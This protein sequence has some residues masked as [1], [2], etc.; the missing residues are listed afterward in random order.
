M[1]THDTR[2]PS[3]DEVLES[4]RS[5]E[6]S[7][8][9]I[10]ASA[11]R[12][13]ARLGIAGSAPG[14]PI[15]IES[16]AGF[17]ALIPAFLDG[18]LP[19]ETALLL[20]DHTRECIPCRRALI[21]ARTPK[22]VPAA[23]AAAR[24]PYVRWAAAAA[25]AAVV[26]LGGYT[27]WQVLPMLSGDPKL[28]VVRVDGTLYQVTAGT[29]V[30]LRP[31]M[32]VPAKSGVRTAKDSG[33]LL[34]IDDGSRIEMRER[35]DLAVA[36]RRDGSTVRLG[37]GAI[38]VEASPQGAGHLDVRTDDCQVAVK[39]T[40]FSVNTGTKGSRVSVVEGAVEV[41]ADGRESLLKPGDQMTTSDSV[42]PVA[43][44]DEIA[45]SKDAPRYAQLLRELASLRKDLDARVQAPGMRFSSDLLDRMP[46][47]TILYAAIPNLT[48]ALVT[49][50]SVFEE[51]VAQ[52]GALQ[53]W[54]TEHMGSPERQKEMDQAFDKIKE[55]GSQL[56]DEIVLALTQSSDG[57]I[58]GPIL[59][60]DVKDRSAFRQ[61]VAKEMKGVPTDATM[62]FEGRAVRI[63][64]AGPHDA[65]VSAR[66]AAPK[67]APW[68]A[69]A[70]REKLAAAYADGTSWLFGVDLAAI[71]AQA[72]DKALAHGDAHAALWNQMGVL[73]A[74]YLIFE[75][76]DSD[77]GASLRAEISFDQPRRGIVGWLSSPAPLGAAD[78]VSPDAAFAAAAVTKRPEL[79]LAEALSWLTPD[80]A[81]KAASEDLGA[82]QAMAGTMGGDVAIALDGPVLPVPS[83]KLAVEVYDPVA[84]QAAFQSLVADLNRR[85]AESG[86]AGQFVVASES[87]GNRT[88]WTVRFTGPGDGDHAMRYTFSNGYLVAA[89]SRALLDQ[90]IEQRGNGYTL[91]RSKDFASLLPAD[92]QVNVSAF[93]WE[94]LGPTVGPLA[95]QVTGIVDSDQMKSIEAM[96]AESHPRLVTA[97]AEDQ[98][99]IVNARGEDGLGSILGTIVSADS[100]GVLA[101]AVQ[102]AHAHGSA[103]VQ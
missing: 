46:D 95:S 92:G 11:E 63:E 43:V 61:T 22:A 97:Y 7:R 16:C 68:V 36:K 54:W 44:G 24:P 103:P 51:H 66:A 41:A 17:Q 71:L 96:A 42:T 4:I 19:R 50:K 75:R 37:G 99:I 39:G 26:V 90:A 20:E 55:L 38:I 78:F 62:R 30:P 82:L 56:G 76:T 21:A 72:Q 102:Q 98:K 59:M 93:V 2:K 86:S 5:D 88:D 89:P 23:P 9:E 47:G 64:F 83:W 65:A 12:L 35:T 1:S 74:Q 70:F 15:H 28:T 31:G 100:L 67:A 18:A 48:Q 3:L 8:A 40:I 57:A 77:D 73:D 79:A 10:H 69:S 53:S 87:A 13:R 49:A 29:I 6:P 32:T 85:I 45:W 80:E 25:A 58:H 91:T 34:A 52:S 33:A 101:H 14:S 94:H 84:F 27:A 60:A 81:A